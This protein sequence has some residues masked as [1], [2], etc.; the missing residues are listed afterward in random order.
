M[1]KFLKYLLILLPAVLG[2]AILILVKAMPFM[3][4][5]IFAASFFPII[6]GA[7]TWF[8]GLF[9]FS[10]T[11][12]GLYCLILIFVV[13]VLRLIV[14]KLRPFKFF[15]RVLLICSISFFLYVIMH[16]VN[17]YRPTVW[18]FMELETPSGSVEELYEA[19]VDEAKAASSL[20]ENLTEDENK[21]FVLTD[22]ISETLNNIGSVYQ[23]RNMQSLSFL[24]KGASKTKGVLISPLWSYTGI[25]GMYFPLLGEANVNTNVSQSDI[26]FTAAHELA[27]T[28]GIAREDECNFIAYL[29]CTSSENAEYCYSGHL[30]AYSYLA[31]AL[32]SASPELY[33]KATSYISEAVERDLDQQREYYKKYSTGKVAQ[34]SDSVNDAFI[35][36]QGVETGSASYS[37]VV[38]LILAYRNSQK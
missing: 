26:P 7:L 31:N 30:S 12:F 1:F 6:S 32:Y 16:G 25:T 24:K 35:K 14:L 19:C 9:P 38:N 37:E 3:A 10:L 17:F 23:S 33:E 29:A 13:D 22:G 5:N 4:E 15:R 34:V 36:S 27:H 11:E 8:S 28:K 2:A 18:E 21:C 20:R